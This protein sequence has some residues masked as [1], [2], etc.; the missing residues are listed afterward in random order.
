[1]KRKLLSIPALNVFVCFPISA[2]LRAPCIPPYFSATDSLAHQFHALT[3]SDSLCNAARPSGF[4]FDLTSIK[5]QFPCKEILQLVL[6]FMTPVALHFQRSQF[7]I[8]KIVSVS[9]HGISS[10]KMHLTLSFHGKV[11]YQFDITFL[12]LVRVWKPWLRMWKTAN[13]QSKM[14]QGAKWRL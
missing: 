8:L 14:R 5:H 4:L 13:T 11:K 12:V 9:Y 1:M 2:Q 10:I 3:H 7:C 6:L